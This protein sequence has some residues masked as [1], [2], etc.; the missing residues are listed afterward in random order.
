MSF[1][2][3]NSARLA[4]IW[5]TQGGFGEIDPHFSSGRLDKAYRLSPPGIFELGFGIE[6][7]FFDLGSVGETDLS[8]RYQLRRVAVHSLLI[9]LG[10]IFS[11]F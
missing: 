5:L 9:N 7:T 11:V 4:L 8:D 3:I 1:Y 6:I 2:S 10:N